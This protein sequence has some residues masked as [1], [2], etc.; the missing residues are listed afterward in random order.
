MIFSAP[1]GRA[2]WH[3]KLAAPVRILAA[4]V[5]RWFLS[6][7]LGAAGLMAVALTEKGLRT[8]AGASR[9]RR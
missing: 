4:Q 3:T 7:M 1:S 5:S 2:S 9:R 6:K 8:M